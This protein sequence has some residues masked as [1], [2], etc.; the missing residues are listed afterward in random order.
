[1]YAKLAPRYDLIRRPPA[2]SR[3]DGSTKDYAVP[4]EVEVQTVLANITPAHQRLAA[5]ILRPDRL[6]KL[7]CAF[8]CIFE[9]VMCS[10]HVSCSNKDSEKKS[11]WDGTIVV[12]V[13]MQDHV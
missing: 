13:E 7:S 8:L 5:S 4:E 3:Q 6:H 11:R 9:A 2:D 1:M 12:L 10:E